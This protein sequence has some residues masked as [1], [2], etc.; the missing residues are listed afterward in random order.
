MT[1][2][3]LELATQLVIADEGVRLKPYVDTVGKL[4]IGVGRN[5]TDDGITIGEAKALLENDLAAA[6]VDCAALFDGFDRLTPERKAA[7]VDM[8]FN[9]GRARLAGFKFLR[10]AIRAGNWSAAASEIRNSA[11]ARQLP[12]R[13]TRIANIIR[14][15]V[16]KEA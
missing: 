6:F 8:A 2:Q 4:T 9:L 5:L 14:D 13:A 3:D 15:S 11:W 12:A 7:L 1:T 10:A 16:I